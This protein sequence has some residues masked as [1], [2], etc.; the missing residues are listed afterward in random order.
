M[1]NM[2]W[3]N[4]REE[5]K[6]TLNWMSQSFKEGYDKDPEAAQVEEF[7]TN[8]EQTILHSYNK[9]QQN[10]EIEEQSFKI[11][12][13]TFPELKKDIQNA[14]MLY[15]WIIRKI[16]KE[17]YV[18]HPIWVAKIISRITIDRETILW[19]LM[20]DVIEDVTEWKKK[21]TELYDNELI[22]LVESVSEEDKSLSWI[23]RKEAY[24]LHLDT[25]SNRSLIISLADRID[26]LRDMIWN[27]E[28]YG[29]WILD[30]FSAWYEEQVDF[31]VNYTLKISELIENI[32]DS[33]MKGNIEKLYDELMILT[34]YFSTLW[35]EA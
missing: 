19:A 33:T 20:H 12:L 35:N 10:L 15:E 24:I 7:D 8:N 4:S 26:N 16:S 9:L 1:N 17:D 22:E 3:Y 13:D 32:E 34:W 25:V 29:I 11:A 31:L 23:Q 21:L 18:H 14:E 2:K 30:N 27:I 5:D 6:N 28:K